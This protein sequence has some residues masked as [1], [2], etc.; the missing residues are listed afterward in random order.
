MQPHV[1]RAQG[2]IKSAHHKIK[3]AMTGTHRDHLDGP[4]GGAAGAPESAGTSRVGSDVS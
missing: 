2:V 1:S 3:L 4:G